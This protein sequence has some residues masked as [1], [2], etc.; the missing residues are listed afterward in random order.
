MIQHDTVEIENKPHD[1]DRHSQ[2][3][4]LSVTNMKNH[5]DPQMSQMSQMPQMSQM[6]Q[7]QVT[8]GGENLSVG[9]RQL[10]CL[11]RALLRKT[12]V[13]LTFS[14]FSRCRRLFRQNQ[15][16]GAIVSCKA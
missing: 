7:M 14:A 9:Q 8:E 16:K 10:I 13:C 6:S 2:N 11:A 3:G 12:K 1:S 5:A 4:D 15:N